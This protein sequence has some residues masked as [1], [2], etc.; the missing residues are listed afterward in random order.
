MPLP[1]D[2]WEIEVDSGCPPLPAPLAPNGGRFDD[3][4]VEVERCSGTSVPRSK[5]GRGDFFISFLR[6]MSPAEAVRADREEPQT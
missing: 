2:L 5:V 6:G 1:L 4:I 3:W